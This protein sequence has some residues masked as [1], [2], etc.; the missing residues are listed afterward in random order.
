MQVTGAM[1]EV[2]IPIFQQTNWD[3]IINT[4]ST[5]F[6]ELLERRRA[7]IM[8]GNNYTVSTM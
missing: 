5:D 7:H 3:R 8:Y 2:V 1:V 4:L 6:I